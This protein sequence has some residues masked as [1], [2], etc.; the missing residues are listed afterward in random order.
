[1]YSSILYFRL[2]ANNVDVE[3]E[4]THEEERPKDAPLVSAQPVDNRNKTY[5]N[6]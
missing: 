2:V 3:M 4:V 5:N 1:M 6:D